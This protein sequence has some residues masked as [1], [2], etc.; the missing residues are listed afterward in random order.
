MLAFLPGVGEIR[1]ARDLL[2]RESALTGMRL[3]ELFGDQDPREQDAVLR[4][5]GGRKVVLAT[6]VAETSLTIPGVTAV[7]DSGLARRMSHDPGLGLDRLELAPIARAAADQR[8]GR[9]GREAPGLCLRLW[10]A[11]DE[12]GRAAEEVP[13]IRRLDLARVVLEVCA[14]GEP[15]PAR[16]AWFEVPP[17]ASLARARACCSRSARWSPRAATRCA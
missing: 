3:V 5:G 11:A 8:A 15:D 13:E 6:N 12:R 14:F 7:V 10:T 9:A 1:R 2:A 16:F 4:P 17:A